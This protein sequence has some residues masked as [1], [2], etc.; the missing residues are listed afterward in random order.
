MR[1]KD[2]EILDNEIIDSY[3]VKCHCI[4][5]GLVDNG[6][7]YIVPLNFGFTHRGNKRVFY[8]HGANEG[9][10]ISLMKQSPKV[11]FEM[12]T[13]YALIE[14]PKACDYAC[15]FQSIMG[16]GK[17][18]FIEDFDEKRAA[19]NEIMKKETGKTDWTYPDTMLSQTCVYM[20]EVESITCK[21]H[22]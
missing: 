22:L 13:G 9:R 2:R 1:R 19:L 7:A 8:F 16:E 3:I 4:R 6:R 10:K 15:T 12:D 14:G 18:T 11:S 5:L 21:E 17:V 20:V